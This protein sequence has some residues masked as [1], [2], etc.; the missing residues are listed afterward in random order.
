MG[1]RRAMDGDEREDLTLIHLHRFTRCQVIR[2]DDGRFHMRPVELLLTTQVPDQTIRDILHIR[3]TRL[4]VLIIHIREDLGEVI[5]GDCH[6]VLRIDLLRLD[7]R[8][9]RILVILI[10]EHHLMHLEDLRVY[11][12][13]L[14]ERLL[15]ERAELGLRLRLRCLETLELCRDILDML[16]LYDAITLLQNIDR[17]DRRSLI[18]GLSD[19]FFHFL[20]SQILSYRRITDFPGRTFQVP[21]MQH[22]HPDPRPARSPHRPA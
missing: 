8:V 4:H 5:T 2:H 11:L 9:D 1:V 21:Q 17:T 16:A 18:D 6:R 22:P 7:H 10:L 14:L 20:S 3:R 15:I 12:T 13:D 19:V